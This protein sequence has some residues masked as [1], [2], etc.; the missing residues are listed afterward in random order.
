[1]SAPEMTFT[2][3]P[4]PTSEDPHMIVDAIPAAHAAEV[5][6]QP[7]PVDEGAAQARDDRK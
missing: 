1:M 5:E 3:H 6:P 2:V 7:D 4:R